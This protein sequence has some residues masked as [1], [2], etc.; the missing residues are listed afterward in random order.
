MRLPTS[1]LKCGEVQFGEIRKSL[2]G[3][4]PWPAFAKA[5]ALFFGERPARGLS[6]GPRPAAESS[7][8]AVA[9]API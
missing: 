3:L 8:P 6:V 1:Q 9:L 7:P 5:S 4:A 2:K